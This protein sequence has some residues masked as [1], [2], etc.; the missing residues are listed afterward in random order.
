MA[1][2]FGKS[3]PTCSYGWTA[4]S[5]SWRP[6]K[7]PTKPGLPPNG[8]PSR[9]RKLMSEAELGDHFLEAANRRDFDAMMSFF[10]PDAVW[11][12]PVLGT[13]EGAAAIRAFWQ[14]WF[15]SYEEFWVEQEEVL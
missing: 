1:H 12:M 4:S 10:A 15:A 3:G 6:I 9:G 5:C 2:K 7:T 13:F 8:S 11:E 14:D